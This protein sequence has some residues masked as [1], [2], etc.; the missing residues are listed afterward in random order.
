MGGVRKKKG[1]EVTIIFDV[2]KEGPLQGRS[3]GKEQLVQRG[4]KNCCIG[5]RLKIE[6]VAN[7]G[8]CGLRNGGYGVGKGMGRVP[9]RERRGKRG[10]GWKSFLSEGLS[11]PSDGYGRDKG[12]TGP[13]KVK[14]Q[15]LW[16][17]MEKKGRMILAESLLLG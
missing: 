15:S 3:W 11:M 4:G 7:E 17:P 12:E 1:N 16:R 5:R 2:E 9:Y 13:R 8:V 6:A 14:T 10:G